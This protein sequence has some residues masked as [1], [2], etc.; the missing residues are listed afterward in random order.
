MKTT[1]IIDDSVLRRAK[2]HAAT[3]DTTVSEL[4]TQ[5]LLSYLHSCEAT[6]AEARPFS[7]PVFG[8]PSVDHPGVSPARLAELRDDGR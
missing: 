1:L 7:M 6:A 3:C 2:K 8:Q 4:V 5:S